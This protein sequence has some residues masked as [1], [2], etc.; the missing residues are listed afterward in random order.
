MERRR[1]YD[2]EEFSQPIGGWVG[3]EDKP[4]PRKTD[5]AFKIAAAIAGS[6][7][8]I[9]SAVFITAS[10]TKG[11]DGTGMIAA[12]GLALVFGLMAYGFVR[13]IGLI[14]VAAVGALIDGSEWSVSWRIMRH[15][16]GLRATWALLIEAALFLCATGMM[17]YSLLDAVNHRSVYSAAVFVLLAALTWWPFIRRWIQRQPPAR[18]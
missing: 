17:V 12:G 5:I 6:A 10:S 11:L 8:A 14:A 4:T 18:R 2:H 15:D 16:L 13:A 3:R 9:G 7:V 1:V